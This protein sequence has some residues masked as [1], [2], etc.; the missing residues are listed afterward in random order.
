MISY[1]S[2]L[3]STPAACQWF[4]VK[5][6]YRLQST[7]EN[8]N[9]SGCKNWLPEKN[10]APHPGRLCTTQRQKATHLNECCDAS[11]TTQLDKDPIWD[12]D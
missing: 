2:T 11:E 1:A 12:S 10:F 6:E 9:A 3:D 7:A 8:K 5:S 4:F